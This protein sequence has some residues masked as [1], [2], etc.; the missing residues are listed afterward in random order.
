MQYNSISER[1]HIQLQIADIYILLRYPLETPEQR[2]KGKKH[3]TN[4]SA[5]SIPDKFTTICN[6]NIPMRVSSSKTSIET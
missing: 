6:S 5:H 1:P 2:E 4:G 3:S